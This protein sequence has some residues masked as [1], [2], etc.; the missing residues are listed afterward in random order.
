ML[1]GGEEELGNEYPYRYQPLSVCSAFPV[2]P[3]PSQ[4]RGDKPPA[5]K[6]A[7]K[8]EPT[9]RPLKAIR[10]KSSLYLASDCSIQASGAASDGGSRPELHPTCRC[11]LPCRGNISPLGHGCE[12]CVFSV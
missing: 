8:G 1:S 10:H 3:E 7:R 4:H 6:T 5:P 2:D 12:A 9:H 11:N